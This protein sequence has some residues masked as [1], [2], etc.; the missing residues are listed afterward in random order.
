MNGKWGNGI[1]RKIKLMKAGYDFSM[2]QNEIN[3]LL[4]YNQRNKY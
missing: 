1:D 3:Q 2:I 4:G